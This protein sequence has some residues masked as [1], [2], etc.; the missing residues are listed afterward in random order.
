MLKLYKEVEKHNQ[1]K[2]S[3]IYYYIYLVKYN[4]ILLLFLP[5]LVFYSIDL[6][7]LEIFEQNVFYIVCNYDSSLLVLLLLN[8]TVDY[9]IYIVEASFYLREMLIS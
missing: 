5:N 7:S 9:I 6:L 3:I 1:K 2:W 4:Y 8:L